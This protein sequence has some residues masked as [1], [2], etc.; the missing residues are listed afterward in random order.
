M[1]PNACAKS[2]KTSSRSITPPRASSR[3]H[4]GRSASSSATWEISSRVMAYPGRCPGPSACSQHAAA[5]LVALYRLEQGLEVALA[6]AVVSLPLDEFEEH[7]T[8]EGRLRDDLQQQP[9]SDVFARAVQ[10]HD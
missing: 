10:H 1:Y 8:A 9:R 5:H 2:A 3:R 7:R 4:A 6:G